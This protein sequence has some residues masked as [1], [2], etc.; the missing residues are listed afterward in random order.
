MKMM[1]ALQMQDTYR[2]KSV[3]LWLAASILVPIFLSQQAAAQLRLDITEGQVEP[4]PVAIAD[5]TGQDGL[6]SAVGREIAQI[7]SNDL[8][9]SGLFKAVDQAAFI[10]PPEISSHPACF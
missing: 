2:I 6:P 5:F 8:V 7:I 4:I 3:I 9:S 10:A 1:K